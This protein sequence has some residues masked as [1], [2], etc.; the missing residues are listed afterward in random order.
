MK[1]IQMTMDEE[2]L[3]SV[4]KVIHKR[5]TTRSAF[6]RESVRFYLEKLKINELEQKHRDGYMKH[7]VKPNEFDIWEDEQ[8]WGN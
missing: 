5:K 1:T 4:D 8:V 3:F 7:P 6:F 2:L